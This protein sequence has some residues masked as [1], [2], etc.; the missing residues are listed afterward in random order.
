MLIYI[1]LGVICDRCY[2]SVVCMPVHPSVTLVHR[3]KSVGW[4]E[5]PFGRD[6]HVVP[7]DI[8][9]H[10]GP[11]PPLRDRKIGSKPPVCSDAI[12]H[13]ISLAFVY[14]RDYGL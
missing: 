2:R 12:Y 5:M 6:I 11:V 3:A 14:V 7:S 4:N 9:L 13:L 10:G 8:V 1:L